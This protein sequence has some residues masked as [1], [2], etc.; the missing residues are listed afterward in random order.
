MAVASTV[1][2]GVLTSGGGSPSF[3]IAGGN[4][5]LLQQTGDGTGLVLKYNPAGGNSGAR[6]TWQQIR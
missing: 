4:T 6:V 5:F 1:V 3:V 2:S